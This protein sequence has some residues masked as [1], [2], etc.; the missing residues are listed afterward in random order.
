SSLSTLSDSTG[1]TSPSLTDEEDAHYNNV[2]F[3]GVDSPVLLTTTIHHMVESS[4]TLNPSPPPFASHSPIHAYTP[5]PATPSTAS[6]PSP[7]SHGPP[8]PRVP[9]RRRSA[10]ESTGSE[11]GSSTSRAHPV[12]KPRLPVPGESSFQLDVQVPS[13]TPVTPL[14]APMGRT[15]QRVDRSACKCPD[16]SQKPARHWKTACPYNPDRLRFDCPHCTESFSRRD[17]RDRHVE[18][19]H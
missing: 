14:E 4:M 9:K 3:H 12:K 2:I 7:T 17:N 16:K 8:S 5:V 19:F 18:D 13:F 6:S 15:R 1:L 11:P 10:T